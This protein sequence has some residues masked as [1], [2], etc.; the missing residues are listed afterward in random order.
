M[1]MLFHQQN[2]IQS[3]VDG[4]NVCIF[5]YGQ[6][7]SGKTYTLIGD[8]SKEDTRGIAPRAFHTIFEL[9]ES[10]RGKLS[11]NIKLYMVE[12]YNDKLLDLLNECSKLEYTKVQL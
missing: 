5:A 3:A 10:N 2:L 4:Y 12:L 1:Q 8:S 6:T 9:V 11:F 7:G